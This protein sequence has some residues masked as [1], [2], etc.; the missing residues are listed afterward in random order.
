ECCKRRPAMVNPSYRFL[1]DRARILAPI[2]IA[3]LKAVVWSVLVA[4]Q[5]M[6]ATG[7]TAPSEREA[8]F[9]PPAV[10]EPAS[11]RPQT[12]GTP[13]N[14]EMRGDIFMARKMYREAVEAYQDGPTGSAV[15]VNKIGIAY[16]QQ[17]MLDRARSFYEKAMK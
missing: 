2:F 5:V 14:A 8:S 12:P 1:V 3:A 11:A 4:G 13:L 15:L 10:G 6:A 7:Q 16:H 17:L 9:R